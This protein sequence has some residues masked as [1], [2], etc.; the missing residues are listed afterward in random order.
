MEMLLRL[1]VTAIAS[2]VAGVGGAGVGLLIAM[3]IGRLFSA[4]E[5]GTYIGL[6]LAIAL[7]PLAA[8]SACWLVAVFVWQSIG[9]RPRSVA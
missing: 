1:A 8:I 7:V 3:L 9:R 2:V 6:L 4:H 5:P